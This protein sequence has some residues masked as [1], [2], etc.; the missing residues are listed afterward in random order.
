MANWTTLKAAIADIIKTNG[1]QEITGQLMQNTLNNIVSS[2]GENSTYAGI[3]IPTTN[4]GAP[5]GPVFY[6]ATKPGTYFNFNGIVVNNNETAV[7]EWKNGAW[8]K[9]S[10]GFASETSVNS[11]LSTISRGLRFTYWSP[12]QEPTI[13]SISDTLY[14]ITYNRLTLVDLLT[15][16]IYGTFAAKSAVVNVSK[17]GL[18]LVYADLSGTSV[19]L[20]Y[21]YISRPTSADEAGDY[22][23][24]TDVTTVLPLLT[25]DENMRIEDI[26]KL[27]SRSQYGNVPS[28][29]TDILNNKA[30]FDSYAKFLNYSKALSD[31]TYWPPSTAPKAEII[32]EDGITRISYDILTIVNMAYWVR[33]TNVEN[34][35]RILQPSPRVIDIPTTTGVF[36]IYYDMA[37]KA[38]H[39]QNIGGAAGTP[40]EYMKVI[41]SP[42][43]VILLL[44]VENNKLYDLLALASRYIPGGFDLSVEGIAKRLY[45]ENVVVGLNPLLYTK[46]KWDITGSKENTTDIDVRLSA[47][48]HHK[49]KFLYIRG[50]V[51]YEEGKFVSPRIYIDNNKFAVGENKNTFGPYDLTCDEEG[52]FDEYVAIP[53]SAWNDV[54]FET[55]GYNMFVILLNGN[56]YPVSLFVYESFVGDYPGKE[57]VIVLPNEQIEDTIK[58]AEQL[59]TFI[60]IDESDAVFGNNNPEANLTNIFPIAAHVDFSATTTNS[61]AKSD[62]FLTEIT[63][64]VNNAGTYTFKV[65]LLDQYPRFVP[66]YEFTLNLANG[67]NVID[68]S[69]M[70]I[71]IAKGEQLA[72]SCTSNAGTS[73][74]SSIRYK[75]NSEAIE[76]EL[77]YGNNNS[78]WAKLDAT[79]GGEIVLSYKMKTLETIFALKSQIE[80]LNEQ[81][82]KQNDTINSLRYVYDNNG[83]PYKLSIY[84]GEIVVKS[85]QYK[86]VLALGNSLTSHHYA[87]NIGYYG[88]VEWAMASTNK[89]TTT[90]TNHLQTILRQKQSDATVTP[91][92]ISAWETN[93]MGVNLDTLFASHKGIEYDLIVIRA[94][95][96]GTA[97]SDYA[98]GVDRLVTFLRTNFP[99]ADIIITDMFWHNSVKEAGFREIAEKYNYPYISFGNIADRCLLGQ[100]L[101]GRDDEFHPITHNGVAGHYTDVC[102]FDFANILANALSYETISG[103]HTVTVNSSKEYGLNNTSQIYNGYVTILTY[104]SSEPTVNVEKSSGGLISTE[105]MSLSGVSWINVPSQIPTYAVVFKMP[106]EDVIVSY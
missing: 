59:N 11:I 71:P 99:L 38:F 18:L 63:A 60:K 50:K 96:N 35:S 86:K 102:F 54:D 79:Y 12:T 55:Y 32:E 48:L 72:I 97:G 44:L 75:Q 69:S 91:F 22:K 58:Y 94:G 21:D 45:P 81:I 84:N 101:M 53:E 20:Y 39:Y 67:R 30:E 17:K 70:N 61:E 76:H 4:P 29:I 85:M 93:Y 7:L 31:Y 36:I 43:D 78:T 52:N 64:L 92:N 104:G 16:K 68:V 9:S 8:T 77:F 42:R 3:A 13:E 41:T 27:Q 5:D 47:R 19:E 103:K 82:E 40:T 65:G 62:G 15:H 57:N 25:V 56:N 34:S 51:V 98:Q 33:G 100:M 6:L 89:I 26:M 24:I 106:D 1:N 80:Q 28:V 105:V 73:G 90:W 74:N 37:D 88:D 83:V 66:S 2:I 14:A 49:H 87:E 10:S 95:E 23:A 46:Y